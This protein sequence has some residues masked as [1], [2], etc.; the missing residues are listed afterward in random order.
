MNNRPFLNYSIEQLEELADA[1]TSRSARSALLR[2]LRHRNTMRARMLEKRLQDAWRKEGSNGGADR[3]RPTHGETPPGPA[4]SHGAP[5]RNGASP[6]SRPETPGKPPIGHQ[7]RKAIVEPVRSIGKL[8]RR[9]D[10]ELDFISTLMPDSQK[11]DDKVSDQDVVLFDKQTERTKKDNKMKDE[12]DLPEPHQ[13]LLDLLDYVGI[14]ALSK[15]RVIYTLAEYKQPV[16]HEVMLRGLPGVRHAPPSGEDDVWLAIERLQRGQPPTVPGILT[17]WLEVSRDPGCE[18]KPIELRIVNVT[19]EEARRLLAEGLADADDILRAQKPLPD[20]AVADCRDVTLRLTKQ[21]AVRDAI[22]DYVDQCWRPWAESEKPRRRTIAI[23]ETLFALQQTIRGDAAARPLRLVWGIGF[24]LWSRDGTILDHP[25]IEYPVEIELDDKSRILIRPSAEAES[26]L[27]LRPLEEMQLPGVV[28]FR[29]AFERIA[30]DEAMPELSPFEPQSF[31]SILRA[32]VQHLDPGAVYSPDTTTSHVDRAL[33]KPTASLTITDH[34]A[35]YAKPR[36]ENL[37]ARDLLQ[38]QKAVR[39]VAELPPSVRAFVEEP[40][41][42]M[43]PIGGDGGSGGL[44]GGSGRGGGSDDKESFYFPKPFNE[45][46]QAIIRALGR[47]DGVVVQGP[48]GTGK[49]HTIANIICHY[50]ATGKRVLITSKGEAALG[51]LRG[52]LPREIQDLAIALLTTERD[53]L[54]QLE[55]T[56]GLV[57][58]KIGQM[59]AGRLNRDITEHRQ[60]IARLD[61]RV[62]AVDRELEAFARQHLEPLALEDGRS[63]LP[64]KLARSLVEDRDAHAWLPDRPGP[65]PEFEPR[66]TDQD[67]ARAREIRHRLGADLRHAG[68]VLPARQVLPDEGGLSV[69]HRELAMAARMDEELRTGAMPRLA[70]SLPNSVDRVKRLA[71]QLN[72]YFKQCAFVRNTPWA[73]Q[74][75]RRLAAG[76]AVATGERELIAR[77]CD[78]LDALMVKQSAMLAATVV[79]PPGSHQSAALAQAAERGAAGQKPYGLLDFKLAALVKAIRVNGRVPGDAP[80]WRHVRDAIAFQRDA[81]E[82]LHAWPALAALGIPGLGH[83]HD[84][85]LT[86]IGEMA[87]QLRW[88]LQH[89]VMRVALDRECRELFPAGIGADAGVDSPGAVRVLLERLEAVLGRYGLEASRARKSELLRLLDECGGDC[90]EALR[91]LVRERLGNPNDDLDRLVDDYRGHLA[92]AER[93]RHL[94][95]DFTALQDVAARLGE[96]GAE[97]WA[98]ALVEEPVTGTQDEWTPSSWRTSWTWWRYEAQLRRIDGRRRILELGRS[99]AEADDRRRRLFEELVRDSAYF[100]LKRTMTPKVQASL[101]K[102]LAAIKKIGKGTGKGAAIWRRAARDA[103]NDASRAVPCWIMP[104][105]RVS[106]SLPARIGEFDLVIVDEASQSDLFALPALLRG[107]KMLVV[108]DDKQVSPTAAFIAVRELEQL[109]ANFLKDKFFGSLMLPG[110][111]LYDLAGAVFPG[112]KLM[113]R[114]HFRCVEPIIRFSMQFY[115]APDGRDPLHPVRLPTASERL[116]PPL[117]AIHVPHGQKSASQIN[118]AEAEVVVEEIERL[119]RDPEIERR[120]RSIGVVSLLGGKQAELIQ[121]MLLERLGDGPFVRHEIACG[122]S[123]TFQGKERDIMFVSMVECAR[124]ATAKTATMFQQRFN[125]AL[126][127]AR[128]RM[129]LVYSVDEERLKPDD[130][131]AKVLRHYRDPMPGGRRGGADPLELCQS[132]FER[133]VLEHLLN[134]GYRAIPQVQIGAYAID[135]V[136][137]GEDDR[138]LAVELDGDHWHGPDRW[139]EDLFRQ[140]VLERCGWHFWRCW[141][142]SY[143]LDPEACMAD[144]ERE[145]QRMRIETIGASWSPPIYTEFRTAASKETMAVEVMQAE[146]ETIEPEEQ[147]R[148]TAATSSAAASTIEPPPAIELPDSSEVLAIGD[149]FVMVY[150]DDPARQLCLTMTASDHR[151][152]VGL[153]AADHMIFRQFIGAGEE[154]QLDVVIDGN[155]REAVILKIDKAPQVHREPV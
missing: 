5:P 66:V 9:H 73:L 149:R 18:P 38:L 95:P 130:L 58:S 75:E 82:L 96:M 6:T 153:V 155:H 60:Q 54:R 141:G 29:A 79:L 137:E 14:L 78:E 129:V 138:R 74:L 86:G 90:I 112:S 97:R 110:N 81:D 52:H 126:S 116:D 115:P 151:P 123:A 50:L 114:E 41:D 143:H 92:E 147:A 131:K 71:A 55:Q 1:D 32:A 17:P 105:W 108:G 154:E 122:D 22:A 102:F 24:A 43:P 2:E 10:S 145:L 21:P 111:S 107:K 98:K 121:A 150:M 135:I 125:V 104:H 42:E 80:A 152:E 53:G 49:T 83:K 99:R 35:L 119:V 106:E 136:V 118:R 12:L 8:T 101:E 144:L 139:Q 36:D 28:P 57:A 91:T 3:A 100:G 85:V 77:R 146:V 72:D 61:E 88:I 19:A 37:I 68:A 4:E 127:R 67:I 26:R 45:E 56:V 46:Q 124:T 113:L 63:M 47:S 31:E 16:F 128:D 39:D 51:V 34:W 117:I 140:R 15:D 40:S 30:K 11:I 84:G 134:R 93:L 23:Y 25:L 64:E 148:E 65:E 59:D 44:S 69:I 13:H 7:V 109:H 132:G 133:S 76:T 120:R 142:S 70:A 62:R 103:L 89:R 20:H 94:R 48:P 87:T 27:H 33:P